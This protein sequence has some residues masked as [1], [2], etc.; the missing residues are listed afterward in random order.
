MNNQG[1][2]EGFRILDDFVCEAIRDPSVHCATSPRPGRNEGM[3]VVE[4]LIVELGST[5][6]EH[7]EQEGEPRKS[8][9]DP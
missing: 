9:D 2:N 4:E 5:D 3:G 7:S 6:Q 1:H 8:E